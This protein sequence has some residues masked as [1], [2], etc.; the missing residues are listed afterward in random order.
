M[1]GM[2]GIR[3]YGIHP[4]VFVIFVP[5]LFG[6]NKVVPMQYL[7]MPYVMRSFIWHLYGIYTAFIVY[8]AFKRHFSNKVL[9]S[10]SY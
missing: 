6:L 4:P 8:T 2:S 9:Q 7:Y 3:L 10:F 5:N 1:Y